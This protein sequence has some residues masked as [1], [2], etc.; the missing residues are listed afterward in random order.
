MQ[1]FLAK[2]KEEEGF[3]PALTSKETASIQRWE[4]EKA[5]KE[6]GRLIVLSKQ[7]DLTSEEQ[8]K[9]DNALNDQSELLMDLT[10]GAVGGLKI[11]K[12]AVKVVEKGFMKRMVARLKTAFGKN[13]DDLLEEAKVILREEVEKSKKLAVKEADEVATPAA[14][15]TREV[16]ET[17]R[18][19]LLKEV[20]ELKAER[21][22]ARDVA[23]GV[24]PDL[25][26]QVFKRVRDRLE[27]KNVKTAPVNKLATY[28]DEIK[29]LQKGDRYLTSKQI[30]G[31]ESY[32]KAFDDPL[33]V[34]K[35]EIQERFAQR[36]ESFARSFTGRSIPRSIMPTVDI[37]AESAI[38]RRIVDKADELLRGGT[39]VASARLQVFDDIM[40]D[41]KCN[42]CEKMIE[43]ISCGKIVCEVIDGKCFHAGLSIEGMAQRWMS[44][45]A[46][47]SECVRRERKK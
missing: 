29:R 41:G 7:R 23:A 16:A 19:A 35:R 1:E 5:N 15:I 30:D 21:I 2:A 10:F 27:I 45:V 6:I 4:Y 22:V 42:L 31:L 8:V 12:E 17:D 37:K 47:C 34:T 33:L 38:I 11:T 9:F 25:N 28:I 46:K 14:K 43:C 3:L 39:K 32:L 24:E 18:Q 44:Q 36:E 40:R 26:T 20:E 13:P